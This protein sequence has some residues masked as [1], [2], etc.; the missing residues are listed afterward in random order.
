[1]KIDRGVFE[2]IYKI[3]SELLFY[4]CIVG[5]SIYPELLDIYTKM[6]ALENSSNDIVLSN[7][8]SMQPTDLFTHS[9]FFIYCRRTV[10]K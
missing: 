8:D 1:M 4:V 3:C 9:Q 5:D 6:M 10:K 2:N 7:V